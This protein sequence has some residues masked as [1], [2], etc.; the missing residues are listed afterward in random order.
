MAGGR[1]LSYLRRPEYCHPSVCTFIV[2]FSD[3]LTDL[4]LSAY[5]D[6]PNVWGY[7][8]EAAHAFEAIGIASQLWRGDVGD[9]APVSVAAAPIEVVGEP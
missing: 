7:E 8:V 9:L 3:Q 2:C 4:P 5:K 6:T 1:G